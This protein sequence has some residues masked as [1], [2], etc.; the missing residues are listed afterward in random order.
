[1]QRWGRT[2]YIL[3]GLTVLASVTLVP[4]FAFAALPTEGTRSAGHTR[5]TGD[6]RAAPRAGRTLRPK[7][8]VLPSHSSVAFRT[9]RT[10]RTG[11]SAGAVRAG[12]SIFSVGA[13][14]S[15]LAGLADFTILAKVTARPGQTGVTSLTI[16]TF[17]AGG[18]GLSG[19][20]GSAAL[21]IGSG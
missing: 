8:S 2:T 4:A 12:H 7:R 14:F 20:T 13:W 6:A 1:M 18:T 15:R 11:L 10:G 9:R 19:G 21:T 17:H 3:A 5:D 16:G